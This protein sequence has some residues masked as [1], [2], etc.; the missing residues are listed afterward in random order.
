MSTKTY[1]V[2]AVDDDILQLSK[3]EAFIE[4]IEWLELID[5]F[6]NPVKAATAIIKLKPDII[7]ID[8]EMPYLDGYQLLDWLLPKLLE[9]DP[10]PMIVVIS[11]NKA[12]LNNYENRS[13]LAMIYKPDLNTPEVLE[14]AISEGM[15]GRM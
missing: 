11:A 10:M 9:M 14:K 12:R 5:K 3:I 6:T 13:I 4:Q 8:I 15:N 2:I 7:L 1:R